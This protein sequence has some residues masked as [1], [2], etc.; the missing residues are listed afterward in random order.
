MKAIQF[1]HVPSTGDHC[2][3]ETVVMDDGTV[4]IRYLNQ[5]HADDLGWG[6]WEQVAL[7]TESDK[8]FLR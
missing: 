1:T 3:I 7:P 6:P 4:W 2:A 5:K 8:E